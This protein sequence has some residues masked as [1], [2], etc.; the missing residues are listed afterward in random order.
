M[1]TGPGGFEFLRALLQKLGGAVY[2]DVQA[3]TNRIREKKLF[4]FADQCRERLASDGSGPK[5]KSYEFEKAPVPDPPYK[6]ILRDIFSNHHLLG[7][8]V[9]SKGVGMVYSAPGYPVSGDKLYIAPQDAQKLGVEE[10]GQVLIESA[11]GSITKAVSIKK[12]LR[13]GVLEYVAFKERRDAL[14]LAKHMQ[15]VLNVTVKKA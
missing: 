3:V 5:F 13:Q 11:E 14:G 4:E 7:K 1:E 2:T 9:Y 8:D 12:G 15:K 10:R 6:L